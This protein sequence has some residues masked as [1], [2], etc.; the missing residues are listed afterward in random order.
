MTWLMNSPRFLQS[1]GGPPTYVGGQASA[2]PAQST[3]FTWDVNMTGGAASVLSAGDYVVLS[4]A[5]GVQGLRTPAFTVSGNNTGAYSQITGS[6]LVSEGVTFDTRFAVFAKRM[7]ATP[8]TQFTL[9]GWTTSSSDG[10]AYAM[11]AWRNINATTPL[12]VATI[13]A[14]GTGTSRANAGPITPSTS[15]AIVLVCGAG[16]A[17]DLSTPWTTSDLSNFIQD[18]GPDTNDAR[19]AMGSFAWTSGEF[20]PAQFGGGSAD[21]ANSWCAFTMALRPA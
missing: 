19:V 15:G 9:N 12:D 1:S 21:A 10:M 20:N 13:T 8:D 5:V 17:L 2:R 18:Y 7:G 11:Q 6:P 3:D 4:F 16:A 14:T